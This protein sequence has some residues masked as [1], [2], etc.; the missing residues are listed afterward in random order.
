MDKPECKN[1]T[2]D[3]SEDVTCDMCRDH[4]K[5]TPAPAPDCDLQ[6]EVL[7]EVI[8]ERNILRTDNA[9]LIAHCRGLEAKLTNTVSARTFAEVNTELA[10]TKAAHDDEILKLNDIAVA[11]VRGLQA[12]LTAR[13]AREAAYVKTLTRISTHIVTPVNNPEGVFVNTYPL[14]IQRW[15]SEALATKEESPWI[16]VT[17]ETM[18]EAGADVI[19]N[20]DGQTAKGC[21]IRG[22]W[23][24]NGHAVISPNSYFP[25]PTLPINERE[26]VEDGKDN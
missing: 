5:L 3:P 21:Y 7:G 2:F 11:K 4:D 12:E 1:C 9:S 15:I 23:F 19:M 25:I 13:Q 10:T 17:P 18:P 24:T 8:A 16:E 20:H 22:K 14:Q 26:G 6:D